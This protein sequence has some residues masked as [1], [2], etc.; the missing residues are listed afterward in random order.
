MA[1][2]SGVGYAAGSESEFPVAY[3]EPLYQFFLELKVPNLS[4]DFGFDG[5]EG[6]IFEFQALYFGTSTQFK[7]KDYY[8]RNDGK[9]IVK[10]NEFDQE[11]IFVSSIAEFIQEK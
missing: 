9:W 2:G 8:K 10:Q 4:I 6:F 1:S 7:S 11:Q 3:L 5:K